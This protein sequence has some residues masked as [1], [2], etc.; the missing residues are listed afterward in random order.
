MKDIIVSLLVLVNLLVLLAIINDLPKR[1]KEDFYEFMRERKF[2]KKRQA[3]NEA[4]KTEYD[5]IREE[6]ENK[7]GK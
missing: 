5:K 7:D 2:A 3:V 1:I 6:E 4:S